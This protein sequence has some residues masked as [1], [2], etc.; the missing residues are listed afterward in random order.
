[1]KIINLTSP[2]RIVFFQSVFYGTLFI[3]LLIFI[4]LFFTDGNL[5]KV[6]EQCYPITILLVSLLLV[7]IFFSPKNIS[8]NNSGDII[9]IKS[10]AIL[11]KKITKSYESEVTIKKPHIVD[12]YERYA[13][14]KLKR[15]F[16]VVTKHRNKKV[17]YKFDIS[18]VNEQVINKFKQLL[19]Q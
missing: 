4:A 11:R 12:Y 17:K 13:F 10:E 19:N 9:I 1:M 7:L 16:V 2:K 15:Y 8:I 18:G 3:T 14:F 5:S 6:I